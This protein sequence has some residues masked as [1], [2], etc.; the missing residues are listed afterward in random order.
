[1]AIREVAGAVIR[2]AFTPVDIWDDDSPDHPFRMALR[3]NPAAVAPLPDLSADD[4]AQA[5][6]GLP[7]SRLIKLVQAANG[8]PQHP[9][10]DTI[11]RAFFHRYQRYVMAVVI[12]KL[13]WNRDPDLRAGL[14][15]STFLE[16]FSECGDFDADLAPSDWA[17]EGNVKRFLATRAKW[18]VLKYFRDQRANPLVA[19]DPDKL[20][21]PAADKS[22]PALPD[23]DVP[24]E[25]ELHARVLAWKDT[26][27]VRE[28]DIIDAYYND[29]HERQKADRLP[30][31]VVATL[32]K[33]YGITDSA[34]RHIK[35]RLLRQAQEF[36]TGPFTP[37]T[38]ASE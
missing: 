13:R 7:A 36:L 10:A 33:R 30:T 24:D 14:V 27:P 15:N 18:L 8:D 5:F 16:F 38:H 23:D 4:P 20:P 25:S 2:L 35:K 19:V 1:M 34:I 29:L 12:H 37:A 9:E 6:G 11:L 26:L 32:K 28:R 21:E 3:A 17:G 22:G 31:A